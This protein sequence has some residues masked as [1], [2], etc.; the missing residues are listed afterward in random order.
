M[1]KPHDRRTK[2]RNVTDRRMDGQ[3]LSGNYS[4]LHCEQC[5]HAV[6][7]LTSTAKA[8]SARQHAATSQYL[9]PER[10]DMVREVSPSLVRPCGT[11][12]R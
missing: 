8:T 10:R 5:G 4:G 6:K 7:M 1:L 2:H 9:D 11:P 12:C 3:K